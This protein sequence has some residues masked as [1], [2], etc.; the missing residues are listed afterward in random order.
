MTDVQVQASS[1]LPLLP[2]L[3]NVTQ[4]PLWPV[5]LPVCDSPWQVA[6]SS[7]ISSI[8]RYNPGFAF[9]ASFNGLSRPPNRDSPTTCLASAAFFNHKQR[10]HSPFPPVLFLIKSEPHD[11]NLPSSVAFWGWGLTP[12]MNCVYLSFNLL[13]FL[14]WRRSLSLFLP[15]LNSLNTRL[16]SNIKFLL[17]FF[18]LNYVFFLC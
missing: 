5:P 6:H 2:A 18:F 1:D 3:L 11:P 16:G 7:G 17:L 14:G 4:F 9:S 15:L 12:S 8:W 10:F 13:I